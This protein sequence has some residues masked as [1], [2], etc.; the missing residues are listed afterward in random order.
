MAMFTSHAVRRAATRQPTVILLM[1]AAAS[2]AALV[3]LYA[4]Q[5][6][7]SYRLSLS[8]SVA[9]AAESFKGPGSSQMLS[10]GAAQAEL[11]AGQPTAAAKSNSSPWPAVP[12]HP[13][14]EERH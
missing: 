13:G 6:A 2:R 11:F 14:R 1:Y 5:D 7:D 4:P 9:S 12:S 3:H 8:L 10:A